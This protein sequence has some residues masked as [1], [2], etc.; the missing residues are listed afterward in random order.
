MKRKLDRRSVGG[1]PKRT[2]PAA[3]SGL[4][5]AKATRTKPEETPEQEKAPAPHLAVGSYARAAA[6]Y[7]H[8]RERKHRAEGMPRG[9][10]E[11]NPQDPPTGAPPARRWP[12]QGQSE[13]KWHRLP[14]SVRIRGQGPTTRGPSWRHLPGQQ[15]RAALK[16]QVRGP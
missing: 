12:G 10:K 14:S 6:F 7:K 5:L 2:N 1:N 8:L 9:P 4:C 15:A 13:Q 16:C 3:E 11:R